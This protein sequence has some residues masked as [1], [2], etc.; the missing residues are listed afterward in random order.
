MAVHHILS[1]AVYLLGSMDV[2]DE[3]GCMLTETKRSQNSTPS[4]VT[5]IFFKLSFASEGS[6]LL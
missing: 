6:L 5:L 4:R 2:M 3:A 1:I